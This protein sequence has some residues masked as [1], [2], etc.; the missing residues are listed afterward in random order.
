MDRDRCEAWQVTGDQA[1]PAGEVHRRDAILAFLG[2]G[3][4]QAPSPAQA[5][6]AL[7]AARRKVSACQARR[8]PVRPW[9]AGE[10]DL[11]GIRENAAVLAALEIP[12][13]REETAQAYARDHPDRLPALEDM[14]AV[15]T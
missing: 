7:A 13:L 4:F 11:R 6:G 5:I 8:D 2:A 1:I 3:L 12:D 15:L 9:L 14:L 10:V